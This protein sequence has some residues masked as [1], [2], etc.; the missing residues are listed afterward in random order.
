MAH[1]K[2]KR[3]SNRGPKKAKRSAI[4]PSTTRS[5]DPGD[6]TGRNF[7]YQYAYG[8]IL[9]VAAK[10]KKLPYKAIWC[11]HH[12]DFLAER[13]NGTFDGYQIKTSRPET[14]PWTLTD[15]AVIKSIGRFAEL[16]E[17]F[18]DKIE[19]L[20]FVS[21]KECDQVTSESSDDKKRGRSPILFL[22]QIKQCK[23]ADEIQ[24]PYQPVFL[25]LQAK[26]GCSEE[27]LF[28][29]LQRMDIKLG[30]SRNDFEAVISNQH[31]S[32][33]D[34]CQNLSSED[35]DN[36]RD[37]LI[38][39]IHRASTLQVTDG[40]RHFRAVVN[41]EGAD[42]AL[43]TKRLVISEV[44]LSGP[45]RPQ[46][47]FTGT[48]ELVLG[49]KRSHSVLSQKLERGDLA[50][51]TNRMRDL[52][53]DAEYSLLEDAARHPEN[54]PRLLRQIEQLVLGECSEAH[55][56][57]RQSGPPYGATMLIGVQDRLRKIAAENADLVG[58]HQ[59]ECLLGVAALLTSDCRV[60]WSPRFPISQEISS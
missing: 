42:P 56:R 5:R 8:V 4:D 24:L 52:E 16:V 44:I 11:E 19:S 27:L 3:P 18:G 32:T 15:A 26:C 21:N 33:L 45:K 31:I 59:Y 54:Y 1:K 58:K 6:A 20:F 13:I 60:W 30:P 37:E 48:T 51:E 50:D 35:L 14:G 12:E 49:T 28:K 47:L 25:E 34:D 41:G 43:L 38:A 22:Q 7:R 53:R 2:N 17:L 57:A 23:S 29:T 55:L 39:E 40:L 36:I 9:I 10:R 46:F